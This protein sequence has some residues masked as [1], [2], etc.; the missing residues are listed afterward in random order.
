MALIRGKDNC[1]WKRNTK[2]AVKLLIRV[3]TIL[4]LTCALPLI[5]RHQRSE[6]V[7]DP[8]S[9]SCAPCVWPSPALGDPAAFADQRLA[10]GPY[11]TPAF[12]LAILRGTKPLRAPRPDKERPTRR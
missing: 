1:P 5:A 4:L 9:R 7:H 11:R 8:P 6:K 10:A 12:A 3:R 2:V